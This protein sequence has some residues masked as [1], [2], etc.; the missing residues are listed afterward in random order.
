[1]KLSARIDVVHNELE[2]RRL[3]QLDLTVLHEVL[4]DT[5]AQLTGHSKLLQQ[6]LKLLTNVWTSFEDDVL[7]SVV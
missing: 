5:I 2:K 4:Q 6:S 1:M 7:N 3:L